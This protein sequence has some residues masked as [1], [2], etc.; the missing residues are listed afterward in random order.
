MLPDKKLAQWF[1]HVTKDP[2]FKRE[3]IP[4]LAGNKNIPSH[5]CLYE[6]FHSRGLSK[7]VRPNKQRVTWLNQFY[8]HG[9]KVDLTHRVD[10]V[11]RWGRGACTNWVNSFLKRNGNKLLTQPSFNNARL[12][13]CR[14]L[15]ANAYNR[16]GI[17]KYRAHLWLRG[18]GRGFF[19]RGGPI[20]ND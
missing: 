7:Q 12:R 3:G 11:S 14:S 5:R 1:S 16:Q 10:F 20:G 9:L 2:P 13:H 4:R 17:K 15:N 19:H 8:F 6:I 18:E